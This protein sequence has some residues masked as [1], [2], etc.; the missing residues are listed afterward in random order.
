MCFPGVR[1][2]QAASITPAMF[3]L[4]ETQVPLAAYEL[5][6]YLAAKAGNAM[7]RHVTSEVANPC[8]HTPYGHMGT[9]SG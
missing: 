5:N 1:G 3:V 9:C 8:L 6:G 2:A 4:N 7:D